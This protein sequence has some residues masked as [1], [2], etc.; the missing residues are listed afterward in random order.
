MRAG[1][2]HFP[3]PATACLQMKQNLES[4]INTVVYTVRH[5]LAC[6]GK[7]HAVMHERLIKQPSI[8]EAQ[9]Y[10]SNSHWW[11]SMVAD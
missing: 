11:L 1:Q 5:S 9:C 7:V 3:S 10:A 4:R 8:S 6:I 2:I